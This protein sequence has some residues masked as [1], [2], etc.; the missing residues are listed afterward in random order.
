MIYVAI[1]ILAVAIIFNGL[2]VLNHSKRI[3]DLE[4]KNA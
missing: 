3:K 2:T 1:L 4:E